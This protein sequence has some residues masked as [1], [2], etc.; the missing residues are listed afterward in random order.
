MAT[1]TTFTSGAILTAAQMNA[2]PFGLVAAPVNITSNQTGISTITDVTGATVTFTA[3]SGRYYR[4][5]FKCSAVGTGSGTTY[6][7]YRLTFADSS[8]TALDIVDY[9]VVS[10]T[11]SAVL[12]SFQFTATGSVTRKIRCAKLTGGDV[13]LSGNASYPMQFY[14]EDMGTA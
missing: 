8:N 12:I 14:I 2:L 13:R 11:D 3:I 5:T 7:T 1:N 6:S 10:A 9:N 4:A